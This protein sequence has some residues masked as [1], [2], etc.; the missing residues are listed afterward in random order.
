MS[1][2]RPLPDTADGS[3]PD[4]EHIID[5]EDGEMS[6]VEREMHALRALAA[7]PFLDALELAS[8]SGTAARAMRDA[9]SALRRT[10]LVEAD[11]PPARDGEGAGLDGYPPFC[12]AGSASWWGGSYAVGVGWSCR[13]RSTDDVTGGAVLGDHTP[14]PDGL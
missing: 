2:T 1:D 7:M 8:V 6:P 9:V 13:W 11:T 12:C 14:P 4:G 10:G 5:G 3:E